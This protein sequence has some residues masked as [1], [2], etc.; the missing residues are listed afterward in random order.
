MIVRTWHGCVPVKYAEG[1][2]IHLQK[3]GVEHSD[4]TPGNL[5]G[6][7]TKRDAG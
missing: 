2:A 4:S 7:C 1:F 5:G 3:T 6:I